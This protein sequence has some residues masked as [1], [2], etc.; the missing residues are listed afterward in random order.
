M[1]AFIYLFLMNLEFLSVFPLSW[2]QK[3]SSASSFIHS[4][5]IMQILAEFYF[6][7]EWLGSCAYIKHTALLSMTHP[8]VKDAITCMKLGLFRL[9]IHHKVINKWI[10]IFFHSIANQH[11]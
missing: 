10:T 6:L 9:I 4:F 1:H 11:N 2:S 8:L 5:S 7:S 3:R